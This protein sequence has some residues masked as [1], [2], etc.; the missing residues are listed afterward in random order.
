MAIHRLI[1][2][3]HLRPS[4][5]EQQ[6]P[7]ASEVMAGNHTVIDNNQP[8]PKFDAVPVSLPVQRHTHALRMHG[9]SMVNEIRGSIP[10][11]LLI[12]STPSC[13]RC[14]ATTSSL[15]TA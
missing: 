5:T 11:A 2:K 12:M 8:H 14:Q 13:R 1:R 6:V 10:G 4:M 3:G 15:S 7:L 9:D